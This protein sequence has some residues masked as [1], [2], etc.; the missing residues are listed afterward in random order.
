[1]ATTDEFE[2]DTAF[3]HKLQI[4]VARGGYLRRIKG[5]HQAEA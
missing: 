5:N 2:V 1:M 4:T 3:D